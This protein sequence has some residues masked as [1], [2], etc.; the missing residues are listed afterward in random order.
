MQEEL[1]VVEECS[2][3]RRK[4]VGLVCEYCGKTYLKRK[5]KADRSKYCS[6]KCKDDFEKNQ[7]TFKCHNCGKIF[8]RNQSR[9]KNSKYGYYFCS[10]E[11]KDK[12]QSLEGNGEGFRPGHYGEKTNSCEI[13]GEL[14]ANKYC[15]NECKTV[16]TL[17]L[18]YDIAKNMSM[19]DFLGSNA[20]KYYKVRQYCKALYKKKNK[21]CQATGYNKQVE[22]CHIIPVSK[23]DQEKAPIW[24][25]NDERNILFLSPNAHWELDH[26]LLSLADISIEIEKSH[27]QFIEECKINNWL[28]K[29]S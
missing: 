6:V 2:G 29:S 18:S 21:A 19:K 9:T 28:K 11:C 17:K 1:Y 16:G 14:T 22:I 12:S 27:N 5:D 25:I 4:A 15:S 10:R 13:C 8:Q 23:F 24:A 3:K 7:I 26:G 20:V